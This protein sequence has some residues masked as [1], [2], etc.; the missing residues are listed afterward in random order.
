MKKIIVP[1]EKQARWAQL[2]EGCAVSAGVVRL[3]EDETATPA[4][5]PLTKKRGAAPGK[6][7]R[8]RA[9]APK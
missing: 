6:A 7:T 8:Q 1:A 5:A 4:P 2:E 3:P 9:A